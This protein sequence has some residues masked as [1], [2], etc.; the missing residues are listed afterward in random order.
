MDDAAKKAY[1]R[2]NVRMVIGLLVIW[3][4]VSSGAGIL[5]ADALN[6]AVPDFLGFPLGFWFAQQGSIIV[7][8]LLIAI[9]VVYMDRTDKPYG[10]TEYEEE[11]R[12]A[13]SDIQLWT[14]VFVVITFSLYIYIAYRSRVKDTQGFTSPA[15]ALPGLANGAAIAADW[16]SAASFISLAGIVAFSTNGYAGSCLPDGL[17]RRLRVAGAVA[18]AVPAQVRQVHRAGLRR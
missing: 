12:H 6:Q 3:A 10:I 1:W 13:V 9:Y 5:F 16:M 8:V 11:V 17:D 15:A 18:R 4:L 14:L 2:S 7:F